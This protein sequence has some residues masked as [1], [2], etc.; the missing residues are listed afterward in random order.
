MEIR[1]SRFSNKTTFVFGDE[2]FK[3]T[4]KD[5]TGQQSFS[6]PY[7]YIPTDKN[8]LE[9]RNPWFRNVGLFWVLIGV[10]QFTYGL[11]ETGALIPSIWLI[12]GLVCFAIYRIASTRYTVLNTK[13]GS[14]FVIRDGKHEEILH[15]LA[16]RRK[17]QLRTLYGVIDYD[18]DPSVE[19]NKF[20]WLFQEGVIT[21]QE[22]EITLEEI[23]SDRL[24]Q[25]TP[26]A[27]EEM[28]H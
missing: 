22:L 8:E 20:R 2:A 12:L 21:K 23:R 3:Y 9:E 11:F 26:E 28:V 14:I 15:E 4:L 5:T 17:T 7:T 25:S 6:V 13:R 19:M 18:N 10:V 24:D 16:I 27:A 1:Q